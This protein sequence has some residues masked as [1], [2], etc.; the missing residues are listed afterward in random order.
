MGHPPHRVPWRRQDG[1]QFLVE[2]ALDTKGDELTHARVSLLH[3]REAHD[4]QDIRV[5]IRGLDRNNALHQLE[6]LLNEMR[7]AVRRERTSPNPEYDVR[8]A[9]NSC[10]TMSCCNPVIRPAWR[11]EEK[12]SNG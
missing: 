11:E 8:C 7:E 2:T 4:K 9:C 12:T 3:E 5:T 10:C 6:L 1:V